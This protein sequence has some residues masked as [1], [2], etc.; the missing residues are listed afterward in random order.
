MRVVISGKALVGSVTL[1]NKNFSSDPEL[2]LI[3]ERLGGLS[4][5]PYAEGSI[6]V[7]NIFKFFRIDLV[8][9]FTYLDAENIGQFMGVKGLAPRVA[10]K[11]KF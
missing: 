3:P 5:T 11:I 9:R 10:F 1:K 2:I 7:E 8:K 4:L 6:G